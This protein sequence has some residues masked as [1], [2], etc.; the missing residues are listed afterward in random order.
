MGALKPWHLLVGCMCLFTV[1]VAGV[2]A[3]V[4]A[5]TNRKR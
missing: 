2:V 4:L 1:G 5:M 3:A